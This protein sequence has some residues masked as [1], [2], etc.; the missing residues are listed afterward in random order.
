VIPLYLEVSQWLWQT[1]SHC[2]IFTNQSRPLA[3]WLAKKEIGFGF[4]GMS[5]EKACKYSE[6]L[7]KSG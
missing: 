7:P 3:P 1:V 5:A 4:S 6:M 2:L